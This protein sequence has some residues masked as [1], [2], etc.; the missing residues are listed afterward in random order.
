M[1]ISA[2]SHQIMVENFEYVQL[3]ISKKKHK[4]R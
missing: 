1:V 2:I 3:S 4:E